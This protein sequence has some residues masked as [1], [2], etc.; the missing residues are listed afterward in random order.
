M[1]TI[2]PPKNNLEKTKHKKA[3]NA[4][5][6]TQPPMNITSKPS[7]VETVNLN[8]AVSNRLKIDYKTFC[9]QQGRNMN[10]VFEEMFQEY[11]NKY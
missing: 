11:K 2:K 4:V 7:P 10:D 1:V 5:V 3:V 8:L 6:K 9:V